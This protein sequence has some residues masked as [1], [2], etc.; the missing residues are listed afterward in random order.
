MDVVL[1]GD[2]NLHIDNPEDPDA[3]Q[4]IITIEAF[5]LKQHIKFPT[6]QLGHTLDLIATKSTTKL[7]CIPI[8]GPYLS[9]HRMVIIETNNRKLT[10]KTTIQGIQKTNQSRNERVPTKLQQPTNPR[11]DKPR[12]GHRPTQ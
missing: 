5:G 9:D 11:C 8:P 12:G 7:T 4:L 3:D 10:K 6:H 2:L 1:L